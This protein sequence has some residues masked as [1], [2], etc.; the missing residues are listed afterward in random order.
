MKWRTNVDRELKPLGLTHAQYALLGSLSA[1]SAGGEQPSQREL[2]DYTGLEPIYVSK[3][4]RALQQAGFIQR[5]VKPGDSR[6]LRLALTEQGRKILDEAVS[7]VHRL[8]A[9]QTSAIGPPDGPRAREFHDT[10]LALL[11][12]TPLSHRK[13]PR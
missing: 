8:M 5:Q 7:R 11:G 9:E 3:L 12:E 13:D 6:A 10:L 4:T 1:A 2:A